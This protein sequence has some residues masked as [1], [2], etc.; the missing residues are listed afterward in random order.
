MHSTKILLPVA[1][2]TGATLAAQSG[3]LQ[4][5]C[6]ASQSSLIAAAPA[7]PT[8]LSKYFELPAT[9][10]ETGGVSTIT[11]PPSTLEDPE[12]YVDVLCNAAGELASS[13]LAEFKSWGEALL[14][15]GSVHLTDYNNFVTDCV[16]S[17]PAA[18]TITSYLNSILTATGGLCQEATPTPSPSSNG[19]GSGSSYPTSSGAGSSSSPVPTAA[20][21]RATGALAGAAAMGGLIGVVALL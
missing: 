18:S 3:F 10:T 11:L 20:A 6:T 9:V 7:V 12:A 16:T 14:S 5:E 19:T 17:G 1:A 2:L 15:Y 21:A 13:D 8:A 4:P